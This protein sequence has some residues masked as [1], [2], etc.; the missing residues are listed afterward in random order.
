MI[1]L[2]LHPAVTRPV[3]AVAGNRRGSFATT[4][5]GHRGASG[6]AGANGAGKANGASAA[7]KNNDLPAG[8]YVGKSGNAASNVSGDGVAKSNTYTVNPNLIASAR[9]PRVSARKLQA[10]NASK[11][12][13]EERAV[14][15]DR[16]FY[17]LS[18][19]MPNLNSAGGSWII[20]FAAL[21][22]DSESTE[23]HI[24]AAAGGQE[25]DAHEDLSAPSATRKI[26]PA[27]PLELMRQN[28]GGTVILYAVIHRDGTVGNIRVLR[29]VDERLDRYASQAVARWQ[30]EPAMK[31]GTPVDVEATFWIPFRPV[32]QGAGF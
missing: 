16:K 13:D 18:L 22:Q 14:F 21:K 1:A 7:D 4:P 2:S 5:T 20:R 15:G 8:L 9:P 31:N 27:Y 24:R 28:V 6:A 23:S 32:R 11:L 19:N 25:S 3:E 10:E 30:F 17:S 29:S 12:S 26:D